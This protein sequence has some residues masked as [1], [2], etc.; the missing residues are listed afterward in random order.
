MHT[1]KGTL[2]QIAMEIEHMIYRL[3]FALKEVVI[4]QFAS[5]VVI[6]GYDEFGI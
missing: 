3:N 6:L 2:L 1:Y 5:N 4:I